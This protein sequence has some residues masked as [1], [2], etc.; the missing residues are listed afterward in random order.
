[1]SAVQQTDIAGLMLEI[2]RR[3]RAAAKVLA[4]TTTEKKNAA[5]GAAADALDQRRDDILSANALD[6]AAA[7]NGQFPMAWAS[8]GSG[9]HLG[10]W[11]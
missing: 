4:F 3:A 8:S 9:L 1:M 7:Q 11:E 6:M 5:L 2:G 10:S